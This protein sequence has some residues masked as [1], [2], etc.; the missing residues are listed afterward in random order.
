[1][2][3]VLI[4]LGTLVFAVSFV[5]VQRCMKRDADKRAAR[6]WEDRERLLDR[7]PPISPPREIRNRRARRG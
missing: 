4:V 1:M 3:I 2:T 6:Q 7:R 5:F